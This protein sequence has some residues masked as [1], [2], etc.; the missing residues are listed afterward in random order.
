M[1]S[2]DW[3]KS[4]GNKTAFYPATSILLCLLCHLS[5]PVRTDSLLKPVNYFTWF[6]VGCL[7]V[8]GGLMLV[9]LFHRKW[10][11][12]FARKGPFVAVVFLL[13]NI[14]NLVTSKF[15]LV[16]ALFFPSPDRILA[17]YVTDGFFILK[18]FS[19]SLRLLLCGVALGAIAGFVTGVSIGWSAR[20]NYWISPLIRFI[21]PIPSTAWIPLALVIFPTTFVASVFLIALAVWFPMTILTSSGIYNLEKSY[22]E[23]A[24]TLGASRLRQIFTIAI[25]GAMPSM[26]IGFFN[27]ICTSFL[28][29]MSAEMIGVKFGI[30]WYINWKREV[31]AYANVYAGLILIALLCSTIIMGLFKIRDRV[32]SWQKGIIRW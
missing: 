1:I 25:P 2:L 29:L 14:H 18:C 13:I 6:L 30:G 22:I 17:V 16:L 20:I 9:G 28:T 27:G 32:L 4:Q 24:N 8:V 15:D 3:K 12:R 19:Y 11:D 31:M 5:V 26:F 23:V 10:M 7:V 21:G